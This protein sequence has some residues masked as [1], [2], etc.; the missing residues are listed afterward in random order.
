[1]SANLLQRRLT[2]P[3]T[4]T[5][6]P[7]TKLLGIQYF[8]TSP[9]RRLTTLARC[10]RE[11]NLASCAIY[12]PTH[13]QLFQF[14]IPTNRYTR[15]NF[16]MLYVLRVIQSQHLIYSF[17]CGKLDCSDYIIESIKLFLGDEIRM[18][19]P[20]LTV[21]RQGSSKYFPNF[22]TFSPR[23]YLALTWLSPTTVSYV[24]KLRSTQ[25]SDRAFFLFNMLEN[26]RHFTLPCWLLNLESKSRTSAIYFPEIFVQS[27]RG[28]RLWRVCNKIALVAWSAISARVQDSLASVFQSLLFSQSL[29]VP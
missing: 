2:V 16:S 6:K 5:F 12:R 19:Y 13:F 17:P 8:A 1:M 26:S 9:S 25:T 7:Y 29:C 27:T 4:L 21:N 18:W 28:K 20:H 22:T 10:I 15:Y 23:Y 3:G 11:A 14:V 24:M